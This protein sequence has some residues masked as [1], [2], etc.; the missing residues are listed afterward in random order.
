MTESTAPPVA[1]VSRLPVRRR[2]LL[3][4]LKRLGRARTEELAAELE[5]TVSAVRQVLAAVEGQGLVTHSE[6]R[7][8]RGRPKHVFQLT[9]AGDS[10]FPRRYG[11]L[12]N[13]VLGYISERDPALLADLFERRRM[14][15][16]EDA[17]A[18]LAHGDF[19]D[20]VAALAAI[21]DEDGYLADFTALDDG[22][23]LITEHN[24]AILDVA[25]R[26]G[27]ACSSEIAFLR[28]AMPDASIDRVLHII[29]G[30]HVCAYAVRQR[31]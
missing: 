30:A 25:R 13:E 24:C 1:A 6:A 18:R 26:Y 7:V 28:E 21:L 31:A 27:H 29:D 5:V 20:R 15:R 22:S 3:V 4:T 17:R 16:V 2:E 9:D 19:A 12:T 11:D 10:L 14:R 23:Y 8:E